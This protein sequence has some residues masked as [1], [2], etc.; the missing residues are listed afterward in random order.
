MRP[1]FFLIACLVGFS[2]A[3]VAQMTPEEKE[4]QTWMKTA[5]AMVRGLRTNVEG[6]NAEPAASDTQKLVDLFTKVN[7]FWAA[8]DPN[9]AQ[10]A[11]DVQ[12]GFKEVGTLAAAG[13]FTEASAS[14]V[15]TQEKCSGCH[16]IH[17]EKLPDGSY[18]FKY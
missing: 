6:K 2:V 3:A 5:S 4:Y 8:K 10:V 9:A 1:S 13:N 11:L 14:I 15:K 12:A 7:G 17:R 16:D 18:K